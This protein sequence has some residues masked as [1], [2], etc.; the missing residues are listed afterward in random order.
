MSTIQ[1]GGL[2]TGIDTEALIAQ[3]MAAERRTQQMYESRKETYELKKDALSEIGSKL[4]T[5]RTSVKSLSDDSKLR[6]FNVSSSDSDIITAEA[7]Y[8]AYEGNHT[9]IVNQLATAERWVHTAGLE[10][11]EDY[12]GE[13]TFIYSYN[14]KEVIINTTAETTLSDLVGLINND[15]ENPGVTAG[16]LYYNDNYHLVLSG[17]DAGTD[18]EI[19]VNSSSTESWTMNSEFTVDG[20][21]ATLATKIT[22]LDQ[23]SGT[24]GTTNTITIS[25]TDKSGAAIANVEL[26]VNS[27]T[28]IEHLIGEINDAFEGVATARFENGK[29]ILTDDTSG[30]SDISISLGFSSDGGATLEL[31]DETA[32]WEVTEGGAT[33][34]SLAGFT[35]ADFTETQQAQDSQIKVDGWPPAADEWITRSS[36]TIDDVITG[37]TLHLHDVTDETGEQITLNRDIESIKKKVEDFVEAYNDTVAYIKEMTGYNDVLKTAGVLMGDFVVRM[38]KEQ[39]TSPLYSQVDGFIEDLDTFLTAGHIGFELDKDGVLSFDSA[40]FDEA[41]AEDYMGVLAVLG[42]NKSGSSSNSS[43][44][45][46]G[47][48]SD[49]TTAGSYQVK[50]VYDGSGNLSQAFF[51]LSSESDSAYRAATIV[52]NVIIGNSTFDD[53][54]YP[55]NPENGLQVSAPTTGTAGSTIYATINVKQG[56]AGEMEDALD[57]M[58]KATNGSLTI[59]QDHIDDQIE[60]LQ[61]KIDME[62]QRLEVREKRLIMRFANLE[63]TLSLLQSQLS[64]LQM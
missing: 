21:N 31:P 24:L 38:I 6:S 19:S 59:D 47:A 11:A 13:G 54:G 56:F 7:T 9:I 57:R 55:N 58:L 3:L 17:N 32:E 61:D 45:F 12:V 5:L 2:S 22:Q 29:I 62:E 25:G 40:E 14:H 30:A 27:N 41:I 53:N 4:G 35:E 10:Y 16:L 33:T 51:K 64:Y 63:K 8:N 50:I 39:I 34:G 37:V 44:K 26:S 46:Y 1:L 60:L 43:V 18:Y 52:G 23:F 48:S 36:N 15:G 42:A 49:Y 28:R 20:D